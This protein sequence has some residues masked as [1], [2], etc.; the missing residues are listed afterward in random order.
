[1]AKGQKIETKKLYSLIYATFPAECNILGFTD[2]KPLEPKWKNQIRFGLRDAR[3][4]GLIKH[5]GTP[6]SGQWE[7]L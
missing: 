5:I 4:G 7:R 6:K 2:S 3:D 1:M